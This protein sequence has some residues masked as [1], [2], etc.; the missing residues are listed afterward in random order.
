MERKTL[1]VPASSYL[2]EQI[3]SVS[4][5]IATWQR[6]CLWDATI[7]NLMMYKAVM[8]L[9]EIALELEEEELVVC[10]MLRKI[11]PK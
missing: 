8:N 9:K 1:A 11:P 7:S 10:E 4:G 2:V 5:R 3:F 6:S